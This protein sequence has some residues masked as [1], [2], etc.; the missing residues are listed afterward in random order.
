MEKIW[1]ENK[2]YF[3]KAGGSSYRGFK[4]PTENYSNMYDGIPGEIDFG[5]SY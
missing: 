4:L 5:S 1:G 3:E 2:N